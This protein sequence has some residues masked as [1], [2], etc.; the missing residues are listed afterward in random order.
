MTHSRTSSGRRIPLLTTAQPI[1]LP[2]ERVS[3]WVVFRQS[4]PCCYASCKCWSHV[5]SRILMVIAS[6]AVLVMSSS[7]AALAKQLAAPDEAQHPSPTTVNGIETERSGDS[8]IQTDRTGKGAVL[9][10]WGILDAVRTAGRE[11]FKGQ[12]KDFQSELNPS[13]ARMDQFIIQNSSHH[14]TQ[15]TIDAI[16]SQG[17]RQHHSLGNIC[18]GD[19]SKMYLSF[20]ARG[21]AQLRALVSENLSI[22]REPVINPCL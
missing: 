19:A 16:R 12:D 17:T 2:R 6:L 1:L 10:M 13:L 15:A 11:C 22:P 5:M 9:C 14:A 8:V 18:T 7:S 21:V 3:T 20:R 4:E